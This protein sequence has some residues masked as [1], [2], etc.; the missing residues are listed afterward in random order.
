MSLSILSIAA[1][2]WASLSS[3]DIVMGCS[4]R[5]VVISSYKEMGDEGVVNSREIA[6]RDVLVTIDLGTG[7]RPRYVP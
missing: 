6:S 3:I 7:T 2:V 4:T 5:D 1:R